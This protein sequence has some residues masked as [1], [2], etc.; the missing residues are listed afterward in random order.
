MVVERELPQLKTQVTDIL[1]E[2]GES[3]MGGS[4]K[5]MAHGRCEVKSMAN[6][7]AL[8]GR[9]LPALRTHDNLS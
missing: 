2:L 8:L 6:H 5:K 7:L 3:C 4:L 1:N 9:N